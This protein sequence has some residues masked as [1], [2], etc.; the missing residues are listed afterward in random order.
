MGRHV[1]VLLAGT[2]KVQA[3]R[4]DGSA[5]ILALRRAGDIVG[6]LAVVGGGSE[7]RSASVVALE[8]LRG[9]AIPAAGLA[10]A[11]RESVVRALAE[12]RHRGWVATSPRSLV[13]TD[14]DALHVHAR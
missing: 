13:V 4:P 2:A 6:E 12:L 11:S 1:V 7:R 8:P 10:G 3:T 5:A 9:R 14:L